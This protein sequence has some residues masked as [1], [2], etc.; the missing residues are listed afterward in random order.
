M[1]ETK[2]AIAICK[3]ASEVGR[4]LLESRDAAYHWECLADG[5]ESRQHAAEAAKKLWNEEFSDE[6]LDSAVA[7]ARTERFRFVRWS[8]SALA[9]AIALTMV[10]PKS[11]TKVWMLAG[12]PVLALGIAAALTFN[13][14]SHLSFEEKWGL[15]TLSSVTAMIP[16]VPAAS[17]VKAKVVST[18]T[19]AQ[20]PAAEV[21]TR[22]QDEALQLAQ[23]EKYL[24]EKG[25]LSVPMVSASLKSVKD[26]QITGLDAPM[27]LSSANLDLLMTFITCDCDIRLSYSGSWDSRIHE[28]G[29]DGVR[30]FYLRLE[31]VSKDGRRVAYPNFIPGS[32]G[33]DFT[34]TWLQEVPEDYYLKQVQ[35]NL[36]ATM[37]ARNISYGTK[38]AGS[39]TVNFKIPSIHQYQ[40]KV[41]K[42]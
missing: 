28:V 22:Q 20:K 39:M 3:P 33:P 16:S 12:V 32:A 9:R 6:F 34:A 35:S 26:A 40:D 19:P 30:R 1:A 7:H 5:Q 4:L 13:S 2:M 41:N 14:M 31:L 15:P 38:P 24:G 23:V 25:L 37:L 17:E 36:D 10:S 21:Q 8:G 27:R 42:Q 29:N 18:F 11:M